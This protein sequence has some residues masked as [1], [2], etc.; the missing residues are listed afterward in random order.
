MVSRATRKMMDMLAETFKAFEMEI[1]EGKALEIKDEE[2]TL[3]LDGM[4]EPKEYGS[5]KGPQYSLVA[6]SGSGND[7]FKGFVEEEFTSDDDFDGCDFVIESK[8]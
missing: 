1:E 6:G 8:E 5:I 7:D 4:D 2:I 3:L